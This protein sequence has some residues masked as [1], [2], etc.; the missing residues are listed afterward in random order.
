M[1]THL[2]SLSL[3]EKNQQ[4]LIVLGVTLGIISSIAAIILT[5]KQFQHTQIQLKQIKENDTTK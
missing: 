3:H 4:R 1:S 5:I 2:S